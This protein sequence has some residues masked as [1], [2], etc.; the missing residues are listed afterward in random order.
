MTGVHH[1]YSLISKAK[2]GG[3]L[4]HVNNS[5]TPRIIHRHSDEYARWSHVTLSAKGGPIVHI[6]SAYCVRQT[7]ENGTG[8]NTAYMQQEYRAMEEKGTHNPK[9]RAKFFS[10]LE[11]YL[12]INVK[13]K[14][15]LILSMDTNE[16][17][18]PGSALVQ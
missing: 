8:P 6:I 13:A 11:N 15:K 7:S 12:A 1:P 9:P 10:D 16:P 2:P 17:N 18:H 3:T 4:L 5:V 14:D